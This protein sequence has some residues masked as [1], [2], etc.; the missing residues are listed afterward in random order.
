MRQKPLAFVRLAPHAQVL[1]PDT[2]KDIASDV[3]RGDR[4]WR[5]RAFT[6]I[7]LLVVIAIIAILASMLLPA[8]SGAKEKAHR[9]KCMN[10]LKQIGLSTV[11]YTDDS[12]DQL[13][14]TSWGSGLFDIPNWA[15][16]R[17]RP[18]DPYLHKP[19]LGLLWKYYETEAILRCPLDRTNTAT[20]RQREMKV[21]SYIMNGAISGYGTSPLG[22]PG[23][24]FK[25]S[26]FDPND[27]IY[28]EGDERNLANWDNASSRPNEGIT[29]RHNTGSVIASIGGHV[30]YLGFEEWYQLA[31]IGGFRGQKPSRVWCAPDSRFGD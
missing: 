4:G 22:A 5:L 25:A 6:L 12:D 29:Q 1:S 11:L 28:F 27:V 10:N 13:P 14:Y 8:L 16:T 3:S 2:M 31:G 21:T 26:Q 19:R 9:T 23:S 18:A 7:E 15:Y 20:W 17:T 30:E 24:T